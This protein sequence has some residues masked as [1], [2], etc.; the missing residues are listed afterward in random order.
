MYHFK[1]D[2]G[3]YSNSE[4]DKLEY[5][6]ENIIEEGAFE[7]CAGIKER[8][9]KQRS[10]R[11]GHKEKREK[12]LKEIKEQ[13]EAQQKQKKPLSKYANRKGAAHKGRNGRSRRAKPGKTVTNL[14]GRSKLGRH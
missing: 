6:I 2:V 13:R 10:G 3:V 12:I 11:S 7:F 1:E 4:I 5:E 8:I 14:G 9:Q